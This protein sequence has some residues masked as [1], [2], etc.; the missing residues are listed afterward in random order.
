[1]EK[2]INSELLQEIATFLPLASLCRF[3]EVSKEW[4]RFITHPN[5]ASR[6]ARASPPE[7]HI[8]TSERV[9]ATHFHYFAGWE[10][11]DVASKRSF[12][13]NGD[14]LSEF[15]K[16]EGV[17]APC[18]RERSCF[19]RTVHRTILA[20]DGGLWCLSYNIDHVTISTIC[21]PRTH[22]ALLVCNPVLKT[23]KQLPHFAGWSERPEWVVMSTDRASM[24]YEIFFITLAEGALQPNA[25]YIYDSKTTSWRASATI[26]GH[27]NALSGREK[28]SVSVVLRDEFYTLFVHRDGLHAELVS[29]NKVTGVVSCL[30]INVP[31]VATDDY[32]VSLQL[33][34]SNGRLFGVITK[35]GRVKPTIQ[36]SSIE[37][38]EF[39]LAR[40]EYIHL[41]VL[42]GNML[43]WFLNDDGRIIFM[44]EDLEPPVATGLANSI[45][46]CSFAGRSVAYDLSNST[47]QKY[48]DCNSR[49]D[50]RR[51]VDLFASNLCSLCPP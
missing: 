24:E 49:R 48:P 12:L 39:I 26:A 13:L 1:M 40:A 25:A 21:D 51:F 50:G 47:W 32:W 7:E 14:F 30:G 20:A 15:V 9:V 42:R 33:V 11:L 16:R 45:F 28:C 46:L 38:V 35:T 4:N 2:E 8:L 44:S 5:F 3:R 37:I 17:I 10:V 41:S 22:E 18:P 36:M 43:N 23:I 6:H 19:Y 27:L 34:A 29:C 31:C